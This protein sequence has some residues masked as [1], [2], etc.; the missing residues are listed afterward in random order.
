MDWLWQYTEL[1]TM[2]IG[3]EPIRLPRVG[4]HKNYG[5]CMQGE[6][7]SRTTSANSECCKNNAAVLRKVT[8]FLV[9]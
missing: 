9:I 6:Y 5:V 2:V 8:S 1:A 3:S 7:E 4:L